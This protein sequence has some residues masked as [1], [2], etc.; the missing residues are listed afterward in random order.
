MDEYNS[1]NATLHINLYGPTLTELHRL[2]THLSMPHGL[3]HTL[4]LGHSHPEPLV[5]LAALH[6]GFTVIQ[7]S[8]CFSPGLLASCD[9]QG[10]SAS[11]YQDEEFQRDLVSVYTRAGVKVRLTHRQRT[12]K[13]VLNL[14]TKCGSMASIDCQLGVLSLCTR[15][16]NWS[17]W[18][19]ALS[20][21][22]SPSSPVSMSLSKEELSHTFSHLRR[23]LES[24]V[25][26]A[27]TSLSLGKHSPRVQHGNSS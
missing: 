2:S 22:I 15:M 24:S 12:M 1:A 7:V 27:Q 13:R 6:A 8:F 14:F 21:S 26:S 25:L 10:M 19:L 23:C 3:S 9:P 17:C 16:R 11:S 18:L 4:L 5:Q 20:C